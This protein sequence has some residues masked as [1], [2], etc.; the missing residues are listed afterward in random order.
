[1]IDAGC[2]IRDLN[3]AET[4]KIPGLIYLTE[5]IGVETEQRLLEL[6]DAAEW[7]N[8]LQRRVQ[9]Y[10]YRYDYRARRIDTG[11]RLGGLPVWMREV[12]ER[13]IEHGL[14]AAR[15]D[16][17][18]VNEYLPGQ[19]IAPH[20]DCEPC[21]ADGIVSLTLGAGCAMDFLRRETGDMVSLYLQP[22]S[23]V[24]LRSDAR[25]LWQHGIARRKSDQ[26]GGH[27]LPRQRRVS[28]TFR[29]VRLTPIP[30]GAVGS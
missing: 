25:Y 13:L 22:R 3:I 21:F 5:F 8:E 2:L 23:V 26:V 14:V 15:P 27:M 17:V 29:T 16:H 6:V 10:G 24:A 19:G 12:G 9:H 4:G 20:V 18:V 30:G 11:M 1:M 28:I 7:S